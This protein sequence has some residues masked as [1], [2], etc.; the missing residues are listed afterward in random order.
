MEHP[1]TINVAGESPKSRTFGLAAEFSKGGFG[2]HP[3]SKALRVFRIGIKVSVLSDGNDKVDFL[4]STS[5]T[6]MFWGQWDG[7]TE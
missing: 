1:E 4:I 5:F 2:F 3:N 6:G 7:K